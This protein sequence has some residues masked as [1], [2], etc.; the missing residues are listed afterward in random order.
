M[1][2]V[3]SLVSDA[4]T[5]SAAV[6]QQAQI[7]PSLFVLL[8]A[9][10]AVWAVVQAL[11]STMSDDD[12]GPDERTP[13]VEETDRDVCPDCGRVVLAGSGRCESCS[14]VTGDYRK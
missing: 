14:V 8:F 1:D 13:E 2:A 12:T 4:V 10:V 6:E 11:R 7:G 9:L 3:A 5:A